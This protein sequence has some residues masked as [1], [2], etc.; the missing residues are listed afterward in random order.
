MGQV[1]EFGDKAFQL[2][3]YQQ[4]APVLAR[5]MNLM[6]DFITEKLR[7]IAANEDPAGWLTVQDSPLQAVGPGTGNLVVDPTLSNK[8]LLGNVVDGHQEDRAEKA[9]V[10]GWEVFVGGSTDPYNGNTPVAG[11]ALKQSYKFS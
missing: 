2:I 9:L 6:Q 7:K 3:T 5:E 11:V 1:Y 8:L 4:A 10:N